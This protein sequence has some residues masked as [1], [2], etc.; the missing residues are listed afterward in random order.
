MGDFVSFIFWRFK[1]IIIGISLE[2]GSPLM[3]DKAYF[4][5]EIDNYEIL[6][7]KTLHAEWMKYKP[8]RYKII[9]TVV[10]N[11]KYF[12]KFKNNM[13]KP[14]DFLQ[15]I[16]NKL[17]ISEKGE[18]IC[19]AVTD[20]HSDAIIL[21]CSLQYSYPKFVAVVRRNSYGKKIY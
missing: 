7:E 6:L 16:T 14:V 18:Y 21:V 8:Q 19:V 10:L 9:D 15:N 17:E 4:F 5:Y 2:N 13:C 11:N 3:D 20:E 1:G 12:E